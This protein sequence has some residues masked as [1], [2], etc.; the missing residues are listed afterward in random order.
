M[1]SGYW[2]R[3]ALQLAARRVSPSR[4]PLSGDRLQDRDYYTVTLNADDPQD[5]FLLSGIKGDTVLARPWNGEI[6][7]DEPVEIPLCR[8]V[9]LG[10][11]IQYYLRRYDFHSRSSFKFVLASLLGWYRLVAARRDLQTRM[12]NRKSI[13]LQ[14]RY[15]VLNLMVNATLKNKDELFSPYTIIR[16]IYGGKVVQRK[17]LHE[18]INHYQLLLDSLEQEGLMHK[19]NDDLLYV[20]RPSALTVLH[21]Y[22]EDA[23]RHRSSARMQGLMFLIALFSGIAAAIQAWAAYD[24]MTRVPEVKRLLLSFFA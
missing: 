16:Q 3:R 15:D 19:R 21:R 8:F 24:G 5:S 1:N 14:Q 2:L 9:G 13:V 12:Y 4:I 6:Y 7:V 20:I 22:Q 17:D 10:I 23:R 11:S 18:V